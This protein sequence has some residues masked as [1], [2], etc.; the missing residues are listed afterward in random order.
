MSVE[1]PTIH[2]NTDGVIEAIV[3]PVLESWLVHDDGRAIPLY[4]W[5]DLLAENPEHI[6]GMGTCIIKDIIVMLG[7]MNGR[8]NF[9]KFTLKL[10]LKRYPGDGGIECPWPGM[11]DDRPMPFDLG[12]MPFDY[13]M[14]LADTG[15]AERAIDRQEFTRRVSV[16]WEPWLREQLQKGM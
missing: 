16:Y 6:S 13:T 15:Q 2:K 1:A 10:L 7:R 5:H 8:Y 12:R 11:P 9:S 3:Y 14:M 4:G